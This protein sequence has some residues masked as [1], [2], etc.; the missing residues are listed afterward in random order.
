MFYICL[1]VCY[2]LLLVL[3]Y[4][5]YLRVLMSCMFLLCCASYDAVLS[6]LDDCAVPFVCLSACYCL[7]WY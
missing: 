2:C 1:L 7:C 4:W 3:V 6:G 5:L